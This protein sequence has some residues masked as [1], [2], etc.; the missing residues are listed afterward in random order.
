MTN[1]FVNMNRQDLIKTYL[2]KEVHVIYNE[3]GTEID[4][5]GTVLKVTSDGRLVG[6]WGNHEIIPG[7]DYISLGD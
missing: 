5:R 1:G 3:A 6:S 7:H 2:G 4:T